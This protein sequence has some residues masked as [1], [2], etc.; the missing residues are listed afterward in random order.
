MP[1]L[2]FSIK[3]KWS[4]LLAARKGPNN[5]IKL[6]FTLLSVFSMKALIRKRTYWYPLRRQK[7]TRSDKHWSA[8]QETE[9]MTDENP[10]V[11]DFKE[12]NE[13]EDANLR[14]VV[15]KLEI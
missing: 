3:D 11:T 6:I 10:Y 15:K 1:Q 8:E 4:S 7:S 14:E 12:T 13:Q 9:Y 5:A 2:Q